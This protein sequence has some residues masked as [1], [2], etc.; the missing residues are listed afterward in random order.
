M[1]EEHA[2]H[3]LPLYCCQNEPAARAD[4]GRYAILQVHGG[5][6]ADMD[7]ECV[8]PVKLF[9]G[10]DGASL[11]VQIYSLQWR[12]L[13]YRRVPYELVANSVIASTAGHPIWSAV[14]GEIAHRNDHRRNVVWRT[15]PE[16]FWPLV[17]EFAVQNPGEVDFVGLRH[18]VT[19]FW[20][21][22]WFMRWYGLMQHEVCILDFNDSG[23]AAARRILMNW[24]PF[25]D[26]V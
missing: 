17:K 18:I 19:S 12:K 6:Y 13:L 24:L 16:M 15:G 4:V 22:K 9:L 3:W 7:T 10:V 8:R 26:R 23:R 25:G 21:P 2:P 20:L 11:R 14:H 1:I 5:V